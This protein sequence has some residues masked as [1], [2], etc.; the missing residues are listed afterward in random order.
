MSILIIMIFSS[1]LFSI[2]FLIIFLISLYSGQFDDCESP[3]IRILINDKKIY[4]NN[5][6][7]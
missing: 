3:R 5:N 6:K 2:L 1:L 7:S 4:N